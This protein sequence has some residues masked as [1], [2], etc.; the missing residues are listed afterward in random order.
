MSSDAAPL[1]SSPLSAR[2]LPS[3]RLSDAEIARLLSECDN[4]KNMY[5]ESDSFVK[6]RKL[7]TSTLPSENS[8]IVIH[9]DSTVTPT[10]GHHHLH[11]RSSGPLNYDDSIFDS[12]SNS[13]SNSLHSLSV[14]SDSTLWKRFVSNTKYH[15]KSVMGSKAKRILLLSCLFSIMFVIVTI[16]YLY[17]ALKQVQVNY[18]WVMHTDQVK[19]QVT[20][21]QSDLAQAE[22]HVRGYL[23][24]G[25][26]D[27][28]IPDFNTVFSQVLNNLYPSLYELTIDNPVQTQNLQTVLPL[29][30][31][32]QRQHTKLINLRL[33]NV[34][35]NDTAAAVL[36][37]HGANT[38]AHIFDVFNAMLEEENKLLSIRQSKASDS[39]NQMMIIIFVCLITCA[40][41]ILVGV[42]IGFDW[43]TKQLKSMNRKLQVLLSRA[44]EAT[45]MKSI[46]L[47]NMSHEIRT[48]MN[49]ILAMSHLMAT[50]D[51][52]D[53]Q[54]DIIETVI[55]SADAMMRLIND[56]LV[57][58]KIEAGKFDINLELFPLAP[59][60]KLINDMFYIR[61]LAKGITYSPS[62]DPTLPYYIYADS[63]RLRQ[64]LV[65]L[66]DNAIKFTNAG[67]VQFNLRLLS[68]TLITESKTSPTKSGKAIQGNTNILPVKDKVMGTEKIQLK[69]KPQDT[70]KAMEIF[71]SASGTPKS[72]PN[73]SSSIPTSRSSVD[74][75]K[76]ALK[77]SAAENDKEEIKSLGKKSK[78][79][80]TCISYDTKST[81]DKK[82]ADKDKDTDDIVVAQVASQVPSIEI[83]SGTPHSYLLIQVIDSGIGIPV[84]VQKKIFEPFAQADMFT[85]RQF[86][87]TGL[88][89]SISKQLVDMMGGHL[90]VKSQAGYGSIFSIALPLPRIAFEHSKSKREEEEREKLAGALNVCGSGL[91]DSS[92]HNFTTGSSLMVA[93]RNPDNALSLGTPEKVSLHKRSNTSSKSSHTQISSIKWHEDES[94]GYWDVKSISH[95]SRNANST[96]SLESSLDT[97]QPSLQPKHNVEA[98]LDFYKDLIHTPTST[99]LFTG[100]HLLNN[101]T[102][103][104]SSFLSSIAGQDQ[105]SQAPSASVSNVIRTRPK[106]IPVATPLRILVAE[107][108]FINQKVFHCLLERDGHSV[109][110][111]DNGEHAVKLFNKSPFDYDVILMDWH[112]PVIDGLTATSMI[113]QGERKGEDL[114]KKAKE[115][116]YGSNS[117]TAV[118]IPLDVDSND[119]MNADPRIFLQAPSPPRRVSSSRFHIPIVAV[120][121]SAMEED[122]EKCFR[123]GV[124]DIITKPIDA[125]VLSSKLIQLALPEH[126]PKL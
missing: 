21:A 105:T 14:A 68:R 76:L 73:V 39:V 33:D 115:K 63:G 19:A 109:T 17:S 88:G 106:A 72:L 56:L 38:Q 79:S 98:P 32:R 118:S 108:N 69:E 31:R 86:G 124:D 96:R 27:S 116:D 50:T 67:T 11:E 78:S 111:A 125:H 82:D 36:V 9:S 64:V 5:E 89:L 84:D 48:P 95:Q 101:R 4:E 114:D 2:P 43:D 12:R 60:I 65:N 81:E 22:S 123:A 54:A 26:N 57:F 15:I 10:K 92:I 46:F 6:I 119:S 20:T 18:N 117:D 30:Q 80:P 3:N 62:L 58:S 34:A 44:Q 16:I 70:K 28:F 1:S 40:I 121:A 71:G 51:V 29:I 7:P 77:N 24:T 35:F 55:S 42:A 75:R 107:D 37:D 103:H 87:G 126:S 85:T 110:T 97:A 122:R 45:K 8:F 99:S 104:V 53:E 61:A 100:T 90:K 91:S 102:S 49:G 113:R 52:S 94:E 47:A 83:T 13:I 25:N 93:T 66:I 59:F 74:L 23:I 120:T 41:S 112:M